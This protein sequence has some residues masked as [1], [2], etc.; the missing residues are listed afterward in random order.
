MIKS[1]L[2]H[3]NKTTVNLTYV[4][5]GNM[6]LLKLGLVG[7]KVDNMVLLSKDLVRIKRLPLDGNIHSKECPD[8]WRCS[9]KAPLTS[10]LSRSIERLE[11]V[12][13]ENLFHMWSWFR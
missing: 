7:K 10:L 12:C 2:L 11:L 3:S 13:S 6:F 5:S 1:N 8:T 9:T 4:W